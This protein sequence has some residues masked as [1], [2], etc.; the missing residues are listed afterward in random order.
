MLLT[1]FL[2][3]IDVCVPLNYLTCEKNGT[4]EIQHNNNNTC[5]SA[6]KE[7]ATHDICVFGFCFHRYM[8]R[9]LSMAR[10]GRSLIPLPRCCS[11]WENLRPSAV[12]KF[13]EAARETIRFLPLSYIHV[14]NPKTIATPVRIIFYYIIYVH[15]ICDHN[16]GL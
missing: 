3:L 11:G 4:I 10:I 2:I 16:M 9:K 8:C 15:V 12:R 1:F 7:S 6:D 5:E 13:T 14:Q